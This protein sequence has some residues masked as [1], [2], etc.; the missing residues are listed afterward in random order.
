MKR[1][2]RPVSW[3][4]ML[5]SSKTYTTESEKDGK[6]ETTQTVPEYAIVRKATLPDPLYTAQEIDPVDTPFLR[7]HRVGKT[8]FWEFE[9]NF[10]E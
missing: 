5:F 9:C 2:S 6:V 7:D 3:F 1:L 8:E 10:G 4:S